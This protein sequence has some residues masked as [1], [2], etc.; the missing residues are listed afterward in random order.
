MSRFFVSGYSSD[1][2][3]SEEDLLSASEEELISSSSSEDDLSE[4]TEFDED[5]SDDDSDS[6]GPKGPSY[7]LKS[8]F[9][10]GAADSDSDLDDDEG[11][12]VVKSAKDKLLDEMRASIETINTNKRNNEWI[13]ILAEFDKLGRFLIRASQ[14]KLST[15]NFYYKLVGEL[16]DF[17]NETSINEKESDKKMNAAQSRAFNTIKQRVK[18]QTK[19]YQPYLDLYRANPELFDSEEPLDIAP[20]TKDAEATVSERVLS[21]VFTTLRQISE[22]RGKK[23]IDKYEQI[24]IL[25]D[26]LEQFKSGKPFELISIYQMLLSI[27]FDAYSNQS[28]MPVDQWEKNQID[29]NSLLDLLESKADQYQVSELG[30]ATDDIDIEPTANE[31]GIKII[32]GSITSFAERLDDE[33]T[34]FLQ[35]TDPHSTEYIERLKDE[36]KLYKLLVRAQV[37]VEL[38]T[39]EEIRNTTDGEQLARIVLRRLDHIYYK[40]DQLIKINEDQAWKNISGTSSLVGSDADA[41]EVINELSV[42]LSEQANPVY[43]RRALLSSI[44]YNAINNR[45]QKARD[46]FLESQVYATIHHAD[47]SLQVQ[48]N[49]ALVQLGL[50]AFRAGEIEESHQA[51]N[52]IANSQRLKELLGQGFSS[53]YPSQATN[54]EKLKLYPFHMH[55]NLELLECA[56]MTS[57]LL[58]EIPALAAASTKDSKRK[59]SI[60]SFKSKLE[61]HDRQYFTGPPESI[62][63]HLVHA[64]RALQKGDWAN[65]YSLLSSIKIWKLFPDND[66][67]L[68]MLKKQLKV[69]GLR[70]YIFTYKSV[71]SKLSIEK[72]SKVFE[73]ESADVISI[74]K[75][76]IEIGDINATLDE[77]K[78]FINFATDEPQRTKLQE[79]AIVMKEKVGVLSE[80][81]EKTASNG[82]GK[83]QPLQQQQQQ[84]QQKEQQKEQKELLQEENNRF[85]YA[86]VNTNNDEFQASV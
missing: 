34:R 30:K 70:T 24:G 14:Q 73:I 52:E 74:L 83:K 56:F 42:F 15:P 58:I 65:A 31:Q 20:E 17:I 51:L 57:S 44:Y 41:G 55:I 47:S 22:T 21:P 85:R 18:K 81:N 23:N 79:L 80:K 1:S 63:D 53:K 8:S 76:M 40:P 72:L 37:Y 60:K 64:S 16:D 46:L 43:E 12:K 39:P 75:K 50:S 69:E 36:T 54:A 32:S 71:F 6:D 49:R 9:K 27:R 86:N 5:S 3:S 35:N 68:D 19:E 67:L 26:L 29:F 77:N 13:G 38:T 45:Y 10:K 25:E 7:F 84:Q 11:R 62:K 2:S 78:S 82:H 33:F 48:Y 59:A 4:D 61:F 28:F 66:D